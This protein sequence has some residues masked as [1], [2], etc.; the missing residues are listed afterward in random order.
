MPNPEPGIAPIPEPGIV[1]IPE[2]RILVIPEPKIS[3]FSAWLGPRLEGRR[4][5]HCG[6]PAANSNPAGF[7]I[8]A[9][10]LKDSGFSRGPT[11]PPGGS[12]WRWM[13]FWVTEHQGASRT[14]F[15]V[16]AK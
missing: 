6:C 4:V 3:S 11:T 7:G 10:L 12:W 8:R 13:L 2:P 5:G 15:Q 14:G 9:P 16:A 1:V